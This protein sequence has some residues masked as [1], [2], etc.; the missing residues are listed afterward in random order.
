MN[1]EIT[2]EE[3]GKSTDAEILLKYC[4]EGAVDN[5][6]LN[7]GSLKDWD[8]GSDI[9]DVYLEHNDVLDDSQRAAISVM[10]GNFLK[11]NSDLDLDALYEI[12]E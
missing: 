1:N 8:S 3:A 5:I 12:I 4:I 9:V 11:L 7:G 6:K 10:M 2:Y